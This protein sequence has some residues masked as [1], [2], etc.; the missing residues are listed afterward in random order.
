M[1]LTLFLFSYGGSREVRVLNQASGI[2]G[3]KM[4]GYES[5]FLFIF[6]GFICC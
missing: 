5:D 3:I 4:Y 1:R 2:Y 6:S